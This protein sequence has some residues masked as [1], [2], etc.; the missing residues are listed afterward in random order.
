[1]G[2]TTAT[3]GLV[4][5]AAFFTVSVV[6]V[7]S[8]WRR[9]H[10]RRTRKQK[11]AAEKE[12]EEKEAAEEAAEK[13][14]AE[15]EAAARWGAPPRLAVVAAAP[16]GSSLWGE[17]TQEELVESPPPAAPPSPPSGVPPSPPPGVSL[18]Q[19]C[20]RSCGCCGTAGLVDKE[21]GTRAERA[22]GFFSA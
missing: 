13:E 11:E 20:F 19:R 5:R 14:A 22:L 4:A 3:R 8:L 21:E 1:M 16:A 2:G 6:G 17:I 10:W 9:V 18:W 15:K 7:R 12:A